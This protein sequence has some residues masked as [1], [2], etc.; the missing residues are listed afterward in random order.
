MA[1]IPLTSGQIAE[2]RRLLGLQPGDY[3]DAAAVLAW[4]DAA[5]VVADEHE[6]LVLGLG[7]DDGG[8]AASEP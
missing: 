1:E 7:D 2:L 4:L 5:Q 8:S 6:R 3:L